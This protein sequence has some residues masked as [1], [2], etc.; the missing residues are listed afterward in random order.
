MTIIKKG[1]FSEQD[2]IEL[3]AKKIEEI[4]REK[5]KKEKKE[6][7]AEGAGLAYEED[8]DST[9][10]NNIELVKEVEESVIKSK[11]EKILKDAEE[12]VKEM[13]EKAKRDIEAQKKAAW[14]EGFNSGKEEGLD[15]TAAKIKEATALIS[16]AIKEKNKIIAEAK[17]EIL[18]LSLKIAE[19][20]IRSEISL[21]QGICMNIVSEAIGKITDRDNVIIKI[22]RSDLDYVKKNR[23]RLMELIDGV[24]NLNIQEDSSVEPG[25]C[26]IETDLGY[27]DGRISTKLESISIALDRTY[28]DEKIKQAEAGKE[29]GVEAPGEDKQQTEE[30]GGVDFL[31][32]I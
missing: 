29:K 18:K 19:Q 4:L 3:D 24:K 7:E 21:N 27:V 1:K 9:I 11:T 6:A 10:E 32:N 2:P 15:S 13:W 28:E 22:N 30:N 5:R 12:K 31:D 20:I 26:I 23:D 25:G 17:S 8:I 16:G 14:E